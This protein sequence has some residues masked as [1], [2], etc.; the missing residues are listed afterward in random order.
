MDSVKPI[1]R[2]TSAVAEAVMLDIYR[3]MPSWRKLEIVDD[4]NRTARQ[5]AI[6]GLRSRHP[7]DS[8]ARLRRRLLAL[9]L[10]EPKA[11]EVYG[12]LEDFE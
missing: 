1:S 6:I 8:P 4:A 2:D 7:Q 12:P 9:V 10:G 3:R 11:T 5:L